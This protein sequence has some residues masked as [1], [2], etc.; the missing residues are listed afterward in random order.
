M[1]SLRRM[2]EEGKGTDF[3]ISDRSMVGLI[4]PEKRHGT[5]HTVQILETSDYSTDYTKRSTV[6]SLAEGVEVGEEP[7]I[8]AQATS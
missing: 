2:M 4:S 5:T 7:N 1:K 8:I 3:I 6:T